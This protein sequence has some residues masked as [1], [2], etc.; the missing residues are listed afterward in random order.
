MDRPVIILLHNGFD[1]TKTWEPVIPHLEQDFEV[2]HFDR[3]NYGVNFS[4]ENYIEPQDIIAEG[5]EDLE[6]FVEAKLDADARF[7]LWGHCAGGAIALLYGAKHTSRVLGIAG[8]AVG[9]FSDRGLSAK[10]EWLLD[11]FE[12]LPEKYQHHLAVMHGSDVLPILWE[13]IKNH[14]ASYIM[15]PAYDIVPLLGTIICPVFI[16]QGTRDIYFDPSHGQRAV[17][18]MK[19]HGVPVS[20]KII[21]NGNHEIHTSR[22]AET[23]AMVTKALLS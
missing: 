18:S 5:L 17:D 2:L 10:T 12:D 6:N 21:E 15:D 8:E 20:Y 22:P 4:S 16:F 3:R 23:A 13:R 11:R 19:A 1:S 7:Y 9:F 14:R